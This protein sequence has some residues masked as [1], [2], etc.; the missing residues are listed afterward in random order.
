MGKKLAENILA[1][2][3]ERIRTA[4]RA[5]EPD[6]PTTQTEI[7]MGEETDLE[8]ILRQSLKVNNTPPH[9]ETEIVNSEILQ[10][11]KLLIKDKYSTER[12]HL[13]NSRKSERY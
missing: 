7:E 6:R 2:F 13:S 1:A 9:S 4:G 5:E 11:P 8:N 12:Y 10:N 3:Q